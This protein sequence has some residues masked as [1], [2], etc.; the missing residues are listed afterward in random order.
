MN[1]MMRA[2]PGGLMLILAGREGGGGKEDDEIMLCSVIQGLSLSF[3]NKT[4]AAHVASPQL[5]TGMLFGSRRSLSFRRNRSK[6]QVTA[7][8]LRALMASAP[9]RMNARA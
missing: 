2:F 1:T 7:T 5:S 4:R 6:Q 3:L 8:A 9:N